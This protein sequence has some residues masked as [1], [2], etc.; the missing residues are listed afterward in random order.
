MENINGKY[1]WKNINSIIFIFD[2][3]RRNWYTLMSVDTFEHNLSNFMKQMLINV[4]SSYTQYY[5]IA[6]PYHS[7]NTC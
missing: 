6:I 1:K 4:Q 7:K 2:A 5:L 3:I